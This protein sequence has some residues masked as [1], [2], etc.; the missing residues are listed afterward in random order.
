M[1]RATLPAV[2]AYLDHRCGETA[3]GRRSAVLA[4]EAV[5]Q[6]AA[7]VV[8]RLPHPGLGECLFRSL[9]IYAML[10]RHRMPLEFVLGAGPPDEGGRPT[11]HCWVEV[12]G[13]PLLEKASPYGCFRVLLRYPKR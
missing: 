13:R 4:P 9:I 11:L 10:C 12:D 7:A 5:A 1:R 6:I 3:T 2:L 8:R